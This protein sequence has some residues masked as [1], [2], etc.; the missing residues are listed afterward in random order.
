MKK[1]FAA[2]IF[3][4]LALTA[5]KLFVPEPNGF[6]PQPTKINVEPPI[7][8]TKAPNTPFTPVTGNYPDVVFKARDELVS[9]MGISADKIEIVRVETVD[10]PDSCLG[11]KSPGIMCA[12]MITPGYRI[13]LRA[14]ATDYEYH[15]DSRSHI[16]FAGLNPA[17][18]P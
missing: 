3:L 4:L 12:M 8:V 15:S 18:I 16:V 9:T 13:I 11:V 2:C 10:W 6:P 17:F 1:V 14:N 7:E 5:C